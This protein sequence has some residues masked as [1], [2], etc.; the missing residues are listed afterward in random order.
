MFTSKLR[1]RQH[2]QKTQAGRKLLLESLETRNLMAANLTATLS[3]SDHIL[4]VVGT[5]NADSIIVHNSAGKVSVQGISIQYNNN[6][7]L[8]NKASVDRA[9]V[10]HV[11]VKGLAG[12]DTI[13]M[14]ETGMTAGQGLPLYAWGGNGNDRITG[15]SMNDKLYGENGSDVLTGRGGDDLMIGAY[16]NSDA[17]TVGKNDVFY[18]GAGNDT[19]RGGAGNDTLYG[20]AGDDTEFGGDGDDKLVGQIG[21]DSLDG[22]AG[23]DLLVEK[24]GYATLTDTQLTTW[25]NSAYTTDTLASI[26]R[27]TL[28][29]FDVGLNYTYIDAGAFSGSVVLNGTSLPDYFYAS[30]GSSTLT[31]LAGNDYLRG[32]AGDDTL[33]GGAGDDTIVGGIGVDTAIGGDGYDTFSAYSGYAL[34]SDTAYEYWN[35]TNQAYI[36]SSLSGFETA[37]LYSMDE[38]YGYTLLS[39]QNFSGPVTLLGSSLKDYLYGGPANDNI[40]GYGGD[41][42]LYGFAGNDYIL[43]GDGNDTIYGGD[44]DD[45]VWAGAGNDTVY[46]EAGSDTLHGDEGDDMVAAAFNGSTADSSMNYVYGGAGN[47]TLYGGDGDDKMYG[48]D[49]NDWMNGESGRDRLFGGWGDDSLIGGNGDDRLSGDYG[50]DGLW[51]DAGNDEL[52]GGQGDDVLVGG[53]GDDSLVL[54]DGGT[55]DKAWG[56]GGADTFWIDGN[57]S[58]WTFSYDTRYTDSYDT[59]QTVFGFANGADRSLDGDNIADPSDGTYYKNFS[60]NW[61]FSGYGPSQNDVDQQN[62]GDCWLMA[63]CAEMGWMSPQQAQRIVAD[64]GDGTYGVKLGNSFYRVDGDLPTWNDYSTDQ[65]FAGLG[66]QNSLWVAVVEKAYADFRTGANTY[67]SLNGGDPADAMRAFGLTGVD[68]SYYAA[69]SADSGPANSVYSHWDA[70]QDTVICTG[71]VS[72]GSKLVGDHCYSVYA[73]ARDG[74]GNVTSIVVRNPWGDDDTGGNPFVTLTPAELGA[75]EIWVCWGTV[76]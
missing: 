47:D 70:W 66:Q 59:V 50:N 5:N 42:A 1:A 49:G 57:F 8:S 21:T 61:L 34:L 71:A 36:S 3:S 27:A 24:T 53:D 35:A 67:A 2:H 31:G 26:E 74:S 22:G 46:G 28:T 48:E 65:Q 72:D 16:A 4:R 76:A 62:L 20:E 52:I 75:C 37:T 64:F 32:G 19:I 33:D 9:L 6:G 14:D 13:T 44:G 30:K 54:I 7:A 51:G 60:D 25:V 23:T 56:E 68:E 40:Y 63:T 12:Y 38:G 73:V 43:G 45:T 55:T 29:A 39:A 15:G 69:S 10:T 41:D 17:E 18:G 58:S 11:E